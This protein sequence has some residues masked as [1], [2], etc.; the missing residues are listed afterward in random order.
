M[1]Y[2]NE[3][4]YLYYQPIF[5]VVKELL[6]NPEILKYCNWDFVPEYSFNDNGSQE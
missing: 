6:L 2:E 5:D 3:D 1:K 4:Y